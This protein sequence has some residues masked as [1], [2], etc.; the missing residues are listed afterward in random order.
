MLINF[1]ADNINQAINSLFLT[2]AR[3]GIYKEYRKRMSKTSKAGKRKMRNAEIVKR[4]K[5]VREI[6]DAE[7]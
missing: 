5:K 1:T 7:I 2:A 4:Y 3:E 6:Q